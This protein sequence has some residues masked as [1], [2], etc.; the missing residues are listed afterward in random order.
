MLSI[1][2]AASAA[3]IVGFMVKVSTF[4]DGK[5][6]CTPY[7]RNQTQ[8]HWDRVPTNLKLDNCNT[9]PST[10]IVKCYHNAYNSRVGVAGRP[11]RLRVLY[12]CFR[13]ED[14]LYPKH[15]S[16]HVSTHR[17]C[18]DL[19]PRPFSS[20]R[21]KGVV[22]FWRRCGR[23]DRFLGVRMGEKLG[24]V[25]PRLSETVQRGKCGPSSLFN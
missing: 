9:M 4:G 19:N 17:I 13:L 18:T 24:F 21:H 11:H 7:Q 6:P 15:L 23:T 12:S 16:S 3:Q 10:I 2:S 22:G 14:A 25:N 20:H 5:A 1:T 8:Y